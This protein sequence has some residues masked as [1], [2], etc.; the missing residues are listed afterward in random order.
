M[1]CL[2]YKTLSFIICHLVVETWKSLCCG[3]VKKTKLYWFLGFE[4]EDLSSQYI[5][6]VLPKSKKYS[7]LKNMEMYDKILFLPSQKTGWAGASELALISILLTKL[8]STP[9][10]KEPCLEPDS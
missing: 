8:Q 4:K 3:Y 9:N 7:I 6:T 5:K 10:L 1:P 2:L